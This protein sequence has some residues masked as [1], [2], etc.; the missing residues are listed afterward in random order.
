MHGRVREISVLE[1]LV[2][3]SRGGR[4][5]T[6]VL[7]GEEG[8]GKTALL[9]HLRE[10]SRGVQVV[11][12]DGVASEQGLPYAAV[13]RL[14]A[15]LRE[16]LSAVAAPHRHVL[17]SLAGSRSGHVPPS[18][19]EMGLAVHGLLAAAARRHPLLCL[20][21]DA[22]RMDEVSR[23]SLAIAARR[24][25]DER[26]AIVFAQP[27]AA[28]CPHLAS[29]L[30]L[31]VSPLSEQAAQALLADHVRAPLDAR[32][33]ER[34]VAD[35]HGSPRALLSVL[36]ALSPTEMARAWP[37][38]SLP[39]PIPLDLVRQMEGLTASARMVLLVAAAEPFGD[40]VTVL[41]AATHLGLGQQALAEAQSSGLVEFGTRVRFAHPLIR[42]KTY[43]AAALTERRSAHR[44]LARTCDAHLV[45]QRAWH[46]GQAAPS[47]DDVVAA[48]LQEAAETA[49]D[50]DSVTASALYE[51]SAGLTTDRRRRAL[52]LL[53]S[54]AARHRAGNLEQTLDLLDRLHTSAL[55]DEERS[56][57]D[58][59]RAQTQYTLHRDA[60]AVRALHEVAVHA[61]S[62]DSEHARGPLLEVMAAAIYAGRFCPAE[63][64][65]VA[66]RAAH[67]L[68]GAA[69]RPHEV[70]L[71]AV[72]TRTV[73][74]YATAVAPLRRAVNAYLA[75]PA[76][77]DL[78]V[79]GAWLACQAAIDVWD[80]DAWQRL[81]DRRT[82]AAREQRVS[83][84]LPPGLAQRAMAHIHGGR[85]SEAAILVT[86]ADEISQAIGATPIR[87]A[88]LALAAWSGD[89]RQLHALVTVVSKEA[90]RRA[91]GRLLTTVECA[92]AVHCNATGRYEAALRACVGAAQRD[93][94]G[95]RNWLLPE[96][97]EA[98]VR[99]GD[100]DAAAPAVAQLEECARLTGTGWAQGLHLRARA[101]LT[102]GPEAGEYYRRSARKLAATGAVLQTGRTQLLWGEWLRRAGRTAQA[103]VP[104]RAA[105]DIFDRAGAR[106]FAARCAG[107][108]AA[109]GAR[110]AR[111]T[112]SPPTALTAQ[113]QRIAD[114]VAQ[115]ETSK[116]VASALF[117]SPRTVDAHL[118]SIFRKLGISSRRE[119][120]DPS[121]L[122][123]DERR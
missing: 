22:H 86:E 77:T 51:L 57:A 30:H 60:T 105:Y 11:R 27:R 93:E 97:V 59:L 62:L 16:D 21:D 13:Q 115:G 29:L 43:S 1:Q 39:L 103:R 26:V 41:E 117:L 112:S 104:L 7:Q 33:R 98:A 63:D 81:A 36:A 38:P 68:P 101:L 2:E 83:A 55:D 32:V 44:A 79:N 70:L 121:R 78:E 50:R 108:L 88:A 15:H 23:E 85:L 89:E 28:G 65:A 118:R 56:Q 31:T 119:L 73:K 120:R 110:P 37:R 9:D 61:R 107:E 102:D 58:A 19:L 116:E 84:A 99:V 69:T 48:Q 42:T 6:L 109:A 53:A 100:L 20:F 64:L 5:R 87:H 66:A 47:F 90:G 10:V 111:G 71:D 76:A 82:A 94:P 34:L 72:A 14:S 122:V 95:F 24:C 45:E 46:G 96:L 52:R 4:S 113:E 12:V 106:A 25:T 80:G 17:E 18:A 74:G 3:A 91:E 114:R 123:S 75:A 67:C 40:V 35:S 8:I 54:A 49:A 92:Q